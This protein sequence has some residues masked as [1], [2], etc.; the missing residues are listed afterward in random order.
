MACYIAIKTLCLQISWKLSYAN[1]AWSLAQLRPSLFGVRFHKIQKTKLIS[2][3]SKPITVLVVVVIIVFIKKK[4]LVQ[5]IFDPKNSMPNSVSS[6]KKFG[7]K[8]VRSQKVLVQK[9]KVKKNICPK[10]VGSKKFWVQNNF[11]SNK[12][13][14]QKFWMFS[15]LPQT[16]CFFIL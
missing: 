2:I 11:E 14:V 7:Q 15:L 8:K 12:F 1:I 13:C 5:K 16:R 3:V 4:N 10:N 6:K 9:I